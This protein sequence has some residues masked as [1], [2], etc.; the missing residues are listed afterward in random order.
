[1]TETTGRRKII[2]FDPGGTTGWA[3]ADIRGGLCAFTSGML[4]PEDHHYNL[5]LLL[6]DERASSGG[7]RDGLTIVCESFE[8]R[9][10]SRA[11]LILKSCEYIGV[12]KLFANSHFRPDPLI[13]Q[14]A[15][16][17]KIRGKKTEESA[18]VKKRNLQQLGLWSLGPNGEHHA[19]DAYGHLLNYM[20][21]KPG[22]INSELRLELLIKG[23]WK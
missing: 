4:G 22:K 7:E 2:A 5:Y 1:V 20:L 6:E 9:N 17:G 11:G 8:Y 10:D 12:I 14:T 18:F 21:A 13:L 23:G 15:S 16:Q 3:L 19:M